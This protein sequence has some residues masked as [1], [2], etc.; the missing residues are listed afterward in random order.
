MKR[1][2][3]SFR[4]PSGFVYERDGT[5]CRAIFSSYQRNFTKFINSGL[6]G[7][8]LERKLII[9]FFDIPSVFDGA[10]K[11]IRMERIPFISYP[12]EWSFDQL[13]DA[14]LTTLYIQLEALKHGM[15]L[16][17][18]SAYNI[19]F[20]HGNPVLIDQLSFECLENNNVW[21]A[22]RQFVMHFFGPLTLMA[23]ADTR[24]SLQLRNFIDGLPIDYISESLPILTW[25]NP[26][27]FFH[28]HLH[29]RI[30]KKYSGTKDK[31]IDHDKIK[32]NE[33][34]KKIRNPMNL[35][36]SLIAAV[37]KLRCPLSE[38]EW[39]NYYV[40]TN[41]SQKAFAF[42]K[43]VVSRIAEKFSPHRACD[44]GANDGQFS[45]ILANHAEIVISAD[46]D[47]L[48]VNRNYLHTRTNNQCSLAPVL[49]DLGN[50]SPAIGWENEERSSF[51]ER[52]KSDF[53]MGLALVHHLCINNNI[54]MA[55]VGSLF[56]SIAPV[57]LIEFVPKEDSQVQ[58]L[59]S[60]RQDIF[61]EYSI[62]TCIKS[63][64]S[65]YSSVERIPIS[66]SLRTLLLFCK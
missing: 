26:S 20:W 42:K 10:W 37:K 31:L 16:K 43:E 63:F 22:Y 5:F 54:P 51:I 11:T 3:G 38:S 4:D 36:H 59:L 28:I 39:G 30:Q 2:A 53:V 1:I 24:H 44:L 47:P 56:H 48:A 50:P 19:Q 35:V 60:V 13:K 52:A 21:N 15:S 41:Y 45:R 7:K 64:S 40:D 34:S 55:Y 57:A 9:P 66:D 58:R 61:M 18:A 12:Y 25:L 46:I 49:I 17:D 32:I 27:I 23:K 8:L 29:A 62:E 33:T 6:Y 65:F 14:A